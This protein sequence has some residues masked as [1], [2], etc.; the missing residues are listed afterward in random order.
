MRKFAFLA[1]FAS[2]AGLA[3]AQAQTEAQTETLALEQLVLGEETYF[4]ACAGC[5]GGAGR[6]DG[7]MAGVLTVPVA[8]LSGLTARNGG[9][10]PTFLVIHAIDGRSGLRGHGGPMPIF[11]MLMRGDAGVI[12][13]PD[14]TPVITSARILALTAY[15]ETLQEE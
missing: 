7:P 2:G 4:D 5:H 14:G 6:G 11:G 1:V 13:A 3:Q 9:S 15:L 12:D 8:D 10:F